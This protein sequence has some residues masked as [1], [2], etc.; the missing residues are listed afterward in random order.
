MRPSRND[1]LIRAFSAA[2]KSRRLEMQLTQE[3]LAGRIELDRPYITLLEAGTKQPTISV[4]WRIAMGLDLTVSELAA[5][6]DK[7]LA[8]LEP[9]DRGVVLG[10]KVASRGT[11]K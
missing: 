7:R 11:S 8:R 2:I 3:D 5:L 1:L 6:V 9:S 4:L 10:K